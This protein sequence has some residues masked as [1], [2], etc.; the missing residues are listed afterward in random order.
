MKKLLLA[1]SALCLM[2]FAASAADLPYAKARIP[3]PIF[4]WT[5]FYLGAHIGAS[6]TGM[7]SNGFCNQNCYDFGKGDLTQSLA[8]VHGGYNYQINSFVVGVE[9]DINAKFGEGFFAPSNLRM[10]SPWDAS[11]RGRVGVLASPKSLLY[12]T[13]GVAFGEFRTKGA[14]SPNFNPDNTDYGNPD[15]LGGMRLG[16]TVGGGAQYALDGNWSTRL[17]YRYTDWG[18]KTVNWDSGVGV[19]GSLASGLV[20]H[21][22][23]AGL[24]Y[25]FGEPGAPLAAAPGRMPLKA[26]VAPVAMYSWTGLYFGGQVGTSSA[27]MSVPGIGDNGFYTANSSFTQVLA[28]G[29]IGYNYQFSNNVLVGVEGDL[30][31]KFGGGVFD[32]PALKLIPTSNW[33]GSVRARLGYL[34]TPVSL[35]YVTG[36]FAFGNFTTPLHETAVD[37]QNEVLGGD[38]SGW[39]AGAGIQ[40]ALDSNWST[41]IEY[42][43]TDW[44]SKTVAWDAAAV[45]A[46]DSKLTDSRVTTALSYKLGAPAQFG[47]RDTVAVN[48]T[49]FY[50]GGHLGA[51]AA[52]V[53]FGGLTDTDDEFSR[54]TQLLVGGHA[55]FNYQLPGYIVLGAEGDLNAKLGHGFKIDDFLRPTS[56]WD[57]SIRAR[58]GFTATA[59]SL[60]YLT[61]GYAWGN[62]TTPS[63][64][65]DQGEPAQEHIGGSRSGWTW[66]GGIQYALEQNW[67]TRIEYRHT[68]WG[69]KITNEIDP[70]GDISPAKLKDDRVSMGITYQFGGPIIAKY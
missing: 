16:W 5:G 49:G 60:L 4:T 37:D 19:A 17:E 24:S 51:S 39:T 12:L 30:N 50:V 27:K 36:G 10:V 18:S 2:P 8:G 23:N 9:G 44:R 41:R 26:P 68:E 21:R 7:A 47:M 3:A 62:F 15:F 1:S 70:G 6:T 35:V 14:N 22:I 55:G 29:H 28:G 34:V 57:A 63:T 20:D 11:I 48:W 58:V 61:G 13:G 54:F 46:T 56:N 64:G 38:R 65:G 40:Y 66:G 69:S 59:R 42:R 53:G 25:R 33:D 43:Y 52:E 67:S 32:L 31:A 45:I